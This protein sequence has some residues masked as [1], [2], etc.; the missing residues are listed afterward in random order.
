MES[1]NNV[2]LHILIIIPNL[3]S[4]THIESC[5][6][7]SYCIFLAINQSIFMAD[8]SIIDSEGDLHIFWS[9]QLIYVFFTLIVCFTNHFVFSIALLPH[10]PGVVYYH[11]LMGQETKIPRV[12]P[13]LFSKRNLG[14]FCA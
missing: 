14:S 6:I 11:L 10:S 12:S 9:N 8:C 1:F 5:T 3:C 13:L 7:W 2:P 4:N